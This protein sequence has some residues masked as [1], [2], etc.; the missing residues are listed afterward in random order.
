MDKMYFTGHETF[1]CRNYWLKKGLDNIWK[2]N[3][4]NDEDAVV[5]LG[6]GKNMVN[7]IR[8][9]LKAFGLT[10]EKDE[11]KELAKK[12]F[13][14]GDKVDE[15]GY[16]P[17]LEDVGT[18]WLLHYLLVTNKRSSIY[19]LIFN[20][21]RKQRIEFTKDHLQKFIER[22]CKTRELY[23][24]SSSVK[25][26]INVFLNNYLPPSN[27]S[28]GIE[29]SFSGLMYELNLVHFIEKSDID[30]K[31]KKRD[32][33]RIENAIRE[34]LPH[35]V[36]LFCILSNSK[37]GKSITFNELLNDQDSVG[38]VFALSSQGLMEKLEQII[39]NYTKEIVLTDDGGVRVLQIKKDI[40][41]WDVLNSYYA[42]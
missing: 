34:G 13:I 31:G 14:T 9:W 19:H 12:I 22:H 16:D 18:I 28:K 38:S 2:G 5:H 39:S 10:G 42:R 35:Q 1:H 23:F 41:R 27:S 8:F 6:V 37:Y 21:F 40:D 15:V 20:E 32:W 24:H 17:Y 7:S 25:K 11:V 29:D 4:F 36:V 33:Y 30:S 26:D 3:Q